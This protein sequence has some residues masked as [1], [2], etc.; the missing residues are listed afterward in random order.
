MLHF[1][2]PNGVERVE[3]EPKPNNQSPS[4]GRVLGQ[5]AQQNRLLFIGSGEDIPEELGITVHTH[6]EQ[7]S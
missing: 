5:I 2:Y 4:L 1:K 7:R 6:Y 3:L